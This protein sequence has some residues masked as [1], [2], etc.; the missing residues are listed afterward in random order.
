MNLL[1]KIKN[2]LSAHSR[3]KE[4]EAENRGLRADL[5]EMTDINDS[6]ENMCADLMRQNNEL[7]KQIDAISALDAEAMKLL[8][9]EL[10]LIFLEN[11]EPIGEA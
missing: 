5:R 2:L 7:K 9:Q 11:M 10:D 1:N 8:Q 3:A 4:L 6:L